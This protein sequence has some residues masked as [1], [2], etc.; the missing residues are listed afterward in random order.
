MSN[1]VKFKIICRNQE[2]IINKIAKNMNIYNF[3]RK[4]ERCSEFEVDY[5]N[6]K[7]LKKFLDENNIKIESIKNNGLIQ[8]LKKRVF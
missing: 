3:F 8:K 4:D 2:K 1:K 5:K 6:K 7:K